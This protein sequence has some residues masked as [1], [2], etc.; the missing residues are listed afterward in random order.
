MRSVTNRL[1]ALIGLT[2]G[3]AC[4]TATELTP[5]QKGEVEAVLA[6]FRQAWLDGDAERVMKHVSSDFTLYVPGATGSTLVGKDRIRT[7]W[8]PPGDTAYRI[9][10]YDIEGAQTHG[11]GLYAVA[12][13]TSRLG[14]DMVVA[15]SVHNSSTSVSEFV[16]VL[17]REDGGWK[18]YRQI[19]VMRN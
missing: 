16:S 10:R 4:S 11:S 6:D 19:F 7:Y 3:S 9:T 15:D 18:L 17:R 2:A 12:Q 14:W 13:G 8:F 5:A 1:F